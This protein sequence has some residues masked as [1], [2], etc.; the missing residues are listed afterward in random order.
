MISSL[1]PKVVGAATSV[2][3]A[4][5]Y[6]RSIKKAAKKIEKKKAKKREKKL[7]MKHRFHR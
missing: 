3:S 5:D 4:C 6:V 2:C 7:G 1:I